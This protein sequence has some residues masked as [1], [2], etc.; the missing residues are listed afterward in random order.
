MASHSEG[1]RAV[2]LGWDDDP[3]D[4]EALG[5]GRSPWVGLGSPRSHDSGSDLF[6]IPC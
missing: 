2:S 1:L 3:G 6:S 4:R 5:E